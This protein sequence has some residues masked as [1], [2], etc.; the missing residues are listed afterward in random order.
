M[1]EKKL[2]IR[3]LGEKAWAKPEELSG[4]DLVKVQGPGATKSYM[5]VNEVRGRS[6]IE[7]NAAGSDKAWV[8]GNQAFRGK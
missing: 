4:E 6:D 7:V 5:P 2:E 1:N 3:T 8:P